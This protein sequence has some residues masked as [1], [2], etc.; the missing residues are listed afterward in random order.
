M[1]EKYYKKNRSKLLPDIVTH[2]MSRGLSI[3]SAC[4]LA[5]VSMPTFRK[6]MKEDSN[7]ATK[8][9]QAKAYG[10]NRCIDHLW[11][12]IEDNNI[13]AIKF[14]L[15]MRTK[16]FREE[17]IAPQTVLTDDALKSII[18]VLTKNNNLLPTKKVE[19]SEDLNEI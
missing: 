3:E 17:K 2:A 5:G 18:E 10:T 6:W 9:A 15:A 7:Y 11:K 19:E 8:I 1:D 4:D 16:E 14:Y 12:C 13:H